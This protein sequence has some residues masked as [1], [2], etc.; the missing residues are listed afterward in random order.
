ME[1]KAQ[2]VGPPVMP[3]YPSV[4]SSHHSHLSYLLPG[5]SIPTRHE[6]RGG[7][8]TSTRTSLAHELKSGQIGRLT[9]TSRR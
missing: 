1:D 3:R 9:D 4:L 8:L 6:G 2:A 7:E 5:Y